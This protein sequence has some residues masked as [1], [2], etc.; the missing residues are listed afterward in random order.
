MFIFEKLSAGFLI[1]LFFG[2]TYFMS[3]FEKLNDW[4][5]TLTY[6]TNH[7]KTTFFIKYISPILIGIIIFESVVFI[8]LG[9]SLV[10]ILLKDH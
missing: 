7:F 2:I 1:I 9:I 5:G 4:K 6:Y 8:L 3:V 10:T